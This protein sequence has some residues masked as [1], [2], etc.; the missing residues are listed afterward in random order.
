MDKFIRWNRILQT[1]ERERDS[2]AK[3]FQQHK[4]SPQLHNQA[5]TKGK[6]LS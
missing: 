3:H 4:N 2:E 6:L 1:R 5:S